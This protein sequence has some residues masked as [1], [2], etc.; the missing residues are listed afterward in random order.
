MKEFIKRNFAVLLA[1]VLPI[2]LIVIVAISIYFPVLF[3]STR[4]D[5]IYSSC[6]GG[7]YYPY[8]ECNNYFQQHYS[9]VGG[10]LVVN[11]V[12][13]PTIDLSSP[14]SINNYIARVFLHDTEKNESREITLAEAQS[15]TL[16][17]LLTSP[18]G[19]TVTNKYDSGTDFFLFG[20][21]SSSGYYLTKGRSRSKLNLINDDDRYY[22][23]DNFWFIGWVLP[24][25]DR[26]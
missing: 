24:G 14:P 26:N 21:S 13:L 23:P 10:K 18:D 12:I 16:D 3:F 5:F 4:Y 11:P 22:Y 25:R 6:N 20:R 19:T 15:L 7:N 17:S 8:Y 2:I 9:V 1:F